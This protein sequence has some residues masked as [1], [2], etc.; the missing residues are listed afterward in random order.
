MSRGCT[1]GRVHPVHVHRGRARRGH[2]DR[3]RRGGVL[4]LALALATG[5]AT[6]L[7]LTGLATTAAAD[8]PEA[9]ASIT[10][11]S[12]SPSLPKRD[13][14]ITLKGKVTNTSKEPLV[15]LQALFWRDQAPITDADGL[16]SALDSDSNQPVGSR[17]YEK[18]GEFQ[19]LYTVDQPDLA[20]GRSATFT[21]TASVADLALAP[22]DG[23]YLV[24][25]HVLQNGVPLAVARTRIFVPVLSKEPARSLQKATLVVLD[26]QPSWLGPGLL[27]DDHLA[28]DVGPGGRLRVLLDAAARKDA[29]YAVD[30]ALV[31]ELETMRSGYQVRTPDGGATAGSGQADATRWLADLAALRDGHDGYRLLFGSPDVAALAHAHQTDVLEAAAA[32]GKRVEATEDLPLLVLPADGAAD[33]DTLQAAAA[34]QPRAVLLSD[35]ATR[36]AGPLLRSS[37]GTPVLTYVAGGLGGGPGP[38]PSD[39]AVHIQQRSLAASWIET[40]SGS[41]T[42]PAQVRLVQTEAQATSTGQTDPPWARATPLSAVLDRTPSRWSGD[43]RYAASAKD[44]E[45]RPS[46]LAAVA[47]LAS[48]E[49]TWQDLLVDGDAAV[50]TGD[51]AT[52]R[53]A[54][55]SWRGHRAA[56]AA[57]VRPQQASLDTRLT[58]QVRIS[59][60]R[61][62]STVAQQGVEFPITIRNDL[63]PQGDGGT[64]DPDTIRVRLVFESDYSGRLTIAPITEDTIGAL[65]PRSGFTGNAKVVARAN[66]TVPVVAQ[67][68]TKSGLKVGR[69]VPIEV[70]VTQNGTTGWAIAVV[71]GIVLIASTTWRIRQVGRERA[72]QEAVPDDDQGALSS[73]PA[74]ELGPEHDDASVGS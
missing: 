48:S 39:D 34:L 2:R 30:P 37:S 71:A 58:D 27:S 13:G 4:L 63:A 10:L 36:G 69:P 49:H 54:S 67:L 52:A 42:G 56:S 31:A 8:E 62:V 74:T 22:T 60:S 61:K 15:R 59:S 20:P 38:D 25:V 70:R 73:V 14:T 32:A 3:V 57:Y 65:A 50:A 35:S 17:R 53:A 18:P 12:V 51:A 45:L 26:S 47:R 46:Q 44:D 24:G 64:G 5:V 7:G 40:T 21:V 72:R 23:V 41:G 1:R 66:G 33:T 29:S 68:Y 6:V 11:T 19:D 9:L 28:R 55:A 16:Q 43:L